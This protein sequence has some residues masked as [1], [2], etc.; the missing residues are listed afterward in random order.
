MR[1]RTIFPRCALV[2]LGGMRAIRWFG[3]LASAICV[4]CAVAFAWSA[5]AFGRL[6]VVVV[7][8]VYLGAI[9]AA[10]GN[11]LA[12]LHSV[13]LTTGGWMLLPLVGRPKLLVFCASSRAWPALRD[14]LGQRRT[15][16]GVAQVRRLVTMGRGEHL[17]RQVHRE[18]HEHHERDGPLEG[19][20]AAHAIG[21]DARTA[22]RGEDGLRRRNRLPETGVGHAG[23]IPASTT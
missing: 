11:R 20:L 3:R 9:V 7:V 23:R 4:G 21:R 2:Y 13:A 18:D 6:N 17:G 15:I 1:Y 16:R 12:K 8:A 19:R 22:K 10:V 14:R 5:L